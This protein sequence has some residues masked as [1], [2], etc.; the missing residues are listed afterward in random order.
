MKF[1]MSQDYD[2]NKALFDDFTKSFKESRKRNEP[3]CDVTLISKD[4]KKFPAHSFI[5]SIRSPYFKKLFLKGKREKYNLKYDSAIVG[6]ILNYVYGDEKCM[7]HYSTVESVRTFKAAKE[8]KILAYEEEYC[9]YLVKK[10]LCGDTLF[11]IAKKAIALE[12]KTL[13]SGVENFLKIWDDKEENG[14]S[15]WVLGY[16]FT[17]A[18]QKKCKWLLDASCELFHKEA[19]C[20]SDCDIDWMSDEKVRSVFTEES[21]QSLPIYCLPNHAEDVVEIFLEFY[22]PKDENLRV[23]IPQAGKI[24]YPLEKFREAIDWNKLKG[25][26]FI[27]VLESDLIK[28][29]MKPKMITEKMKAETEN[30]GKFKTKIEEETKEFEEKVTKNEARVQELAAK[31]D[32]QKARLAKQ[33]RKLKTINR[34]VKRLAKNCS[35]AT[36]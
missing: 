8:Y 15:Y 22:Y 2:S 14:I 26:L 33:T 23:R 24:M 31:Y 27:D 11:K 19:N 9:E 6:N 28:P 18:V 5:L 36:I 10:R 34:K 4:G 16:L 12:N 1:K 35:H 30:H 13:I 25:D 7:K 21:L 3:P 29:D 20:P 17:L 32:N